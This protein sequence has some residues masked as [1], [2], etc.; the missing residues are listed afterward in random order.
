MAAFSGLSFNRGN[1]EGE[2]S[3]T[4]T[5]NEGLLSSVANSL[6]YSGKRNRNRAQESLGYFIR[7]CLSVIKGEADLDDFPKLKAIVDIAPEVED[8]DGV[9]IEDREM[10]DKNEPE[11]KVKRTRTPKNIV[12]SV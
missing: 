2:G 4:V 6:E 3:V 9:T 10:D 1:R 5:I 12:T 8:E 11:I 7:D